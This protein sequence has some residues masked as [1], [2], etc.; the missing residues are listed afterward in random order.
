MIIM[1]MII[2]MIMIGRRRNNG[3]F[4]KRWI[5]IIQIILEDKV[6]KKKIPNISIS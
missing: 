2:I 5:E 4:A 3:R 6:F 1:M